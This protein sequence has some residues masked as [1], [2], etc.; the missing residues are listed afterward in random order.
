MDNLLKIVISLLLFS[1]QGFSQAL[2]VEAGGGAWM[3]TPKGTVA[4]STS[5]GSGDSTCRETEAAIG[6]AWLYIRHPIPVFPN[7]RLE[8]SAAGSDGDAT[9]DLIAPLGV[10]ATTTSH[11]D[12]KAYDAILYYNLL[13]STFWTTLDLGLD[14][15]V[16]GYTYDVVPTDGLLAYGGYS[17]SG[18]LILPLVYTRLRVDIPGTGLGIEGLGSYITYE[19]SY[20]YDARIK[21]DW[22]LIFV[23]GVQPGIEVGYRMQK[24]KIDDDKE[25]KGD[26]DF[27]GLFVGAFLR[28]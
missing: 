3:Q 24:V 8:Y 28:F 27:S 1:L 18:T 23:P 2:E 7:I 9:V 14:V 10:M 16:A 19:K 15:K 20:V 17:R 25:L 13:N 12:V 22:T 4:Y 5:N 26:V 21:A 11:F 6:Y